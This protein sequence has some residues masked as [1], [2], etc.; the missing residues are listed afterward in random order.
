MWVYA[1]GRYE[2]I[3]QKKDGFYFRLMSQQL[4]GEY[5][6]YN[7][8]ENEWLCERLDEPQIDWTRT[9]VDPMLATSRKGI[10]RSGDWV[11]EMKWDG[12]RALI[13]IDE[14]ELRIHSR[15]RNDITDRFPELRVPEA[16]F[17]TSAVFDG[18]IVCLEPDGRPNFRSVVRR[19]Q[20]TGDASIERARKKT[21]AH[22][23]LFDCLYLDGRPI[24]Q[25]PMMRRHEWLLDAVKRDTAYRVSEVMDDGEAFFEAV[26]AMGL[27][28]VVAKDPSGRYSPGRRSDA[29]QKI[30]VRST[31]TCVILGFTTGKGD[32]QSLFGALQIAE[33][34][35]NG[36][37][38]YRGKVGT[39]FSAAKMKDIKQILNDIS[40]IDR[41]PIDNPL[42]NEQTTWVQPL[43]I[44]E[45]QYA[46]VT[47]NGTFREPV[48]LRLRP[49]LED[50]TATE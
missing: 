30:K 18:E 9:V 21:P 23:Y 26:K 34:S 5:R 41:A 19:L 47:R 10:P 2:I 12:I 25:E 38:V 36:E 16:F 3:K 20:R 14:G 42:D 46:S 24:T 11:Y 13:S 35:D 33:I 15:N 8:R 1:L 48:F 4:T 31:S 44:C 50:E 17:A 49:D 22:C 27:E 32:R 40:V 39:G 7:T 37:F 45:V 43:R 29:W 6:I 28:G